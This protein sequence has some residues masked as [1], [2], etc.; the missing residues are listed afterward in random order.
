M[1]LKDLIERSVSSEMGKIIIMKKGS[2]KTIRFVSLTSIA[3]LVGFA[4]AAWFNPTIIQIGVFI[5][6]LCLSSYFL[7]RW[8]EERRKLEDMKFHHITATIRGV[9]R[10]DIDKLIK[11]M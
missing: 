5:Y 6:W 3:M 8:M 1:D 2:L 9:E 4:V 7:K 11:L 10:E